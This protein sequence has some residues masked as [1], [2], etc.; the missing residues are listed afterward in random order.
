[1][2]VMKNLGNGYISKEDEERAMVEPVIQVADVVET[3]SEVQGDEPVTDV[4]HTT[5]TS[6]HE[7]MQKKR[8]KERP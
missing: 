5:R 1:M 6:P 2:E 7:W 3:I 8:K 4:A